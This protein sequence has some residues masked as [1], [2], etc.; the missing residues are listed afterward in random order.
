LT[1]E[2]FRPVTEL[3]HGVY[4]NGGSSSD[5][6]YLNW[7]YRENPQGAY[8]AVCED[9]GQIIGF[10]ALTP[11]LVKVNHVLSRWAWGGDLMV[12]PQFRRQGIFLA[13]KRCT[14]QEAKGDI[15]VVFA[16]GSLKTPTARGVLKHLGYEHL[17]DI[18]RLKRYISLLSALHS[19]SIQGKI[20]VTSLCN[21]LGS[22]AELFSIT[23]LGD[24]L[25]NFSR[26]ELNHIH[27][28]E[29][30]IHL[31]EIKPLR[32][33]AEFD[34]LWNEVNESLPIAVVRSKEYLNWRYAN[35][36][37]TYVGFRADK[38]G[39]LCGYSIIAYETSGKLKIA[40]VADLLAKK[41]TIASM[42]L[43]I[44]LQRAKQDNAHVVIMYDN[45]EA[46]CLPRNLKLVRAWSKTPMIV[47]FDDPQLPK[48]LVRDVNNWYVTV[49]DTDD[50]I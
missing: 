40:W 22:I 2:D 6:A 28:E 7:K 8:M 30:Q 33:G 35:P 47:R 14:H 43:R 46:E 3:A 26:R 20:T 4:P 25:N 39:A 44:C 37:A 9:E 41:P 18:P 48:D 13:M 16:T 23:L 21:Y 50:W 32:F 24:L 34:E 11:I 1:S 10:Q 27:D 29:E 45:G 12:H 42:L 15:S 38:D 19:L 31:R 17:G 5:P 49:G 36:C